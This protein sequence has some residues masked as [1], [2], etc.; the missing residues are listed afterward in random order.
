MGTAAERRQKLYLD[1]KGGQ[2]PISVHQRRTS[3][4]G[5]CELCYIMVLFFQNMHK[6]ITFSLTPTLLKH[7]TV[8]IVSLVAMSYM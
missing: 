7:N 8:P 5:L 6:T 4:Q 2:G 1:S 3:N